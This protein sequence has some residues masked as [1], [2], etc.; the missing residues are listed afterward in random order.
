MTEENYTPLSS[1]EQKSQTYKLMLW[2]GMVSVVMMFAGMTSAYV[3]SSSRRDWLHDFQLPTAFLWSTVAIVL[4]SITFL[5]AKKAIK[6]NELS[7]TSLFLYLTLGL[8]VVFVALQFFGF[9]QIIASGYFLTGTYSTVTTSFIY[10]LVMM[11]LAHLGAGLLALLYIIYNHYKNKYNAAQSLGIELGE[12]FW[13]FL[14]VLW[15]LLFLF[16]YF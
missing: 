2:F 14:G 10:V 12:L 8:G 11:H 5:L 9:E 16:F 3:I 13:H 15:V 6:R 1:Y 4:S 7:K